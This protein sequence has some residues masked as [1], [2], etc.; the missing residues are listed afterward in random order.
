MVSLSKVT[1]WLVRTLACLAV[2]AW[3]TGCASDSPSGSSGKSGSSGSGSTDARDVDRLKKGDLVTVFFSGVNPPP[4]DQEERIKDDG[5]I[6]LQL[7]GPV[8][9]EGLTPGELQKKLQE[10][11][12]PKYYR[13]LTVTV[14]TENRMFY[15]DGEVRRPDR[16]TYQGEVSVL[17]AIAAAGGF[18]DF[19][20]RGRIQLVR[21]TGEKVSV[22]GRKAAND[23]KYDPLVLP[24]DRVFV[25]R[26]SP[27]GR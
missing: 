16:I 19:A 6:N 8:K 20:A 26:R 12:V 2:V 17:K 7:I 9:A 5:M 25:P 14:K 21:S 3:M 11:Y 4:S 18:T 23:S 22:D 27:F 1:D 13:R 10:S 15:V 24:G